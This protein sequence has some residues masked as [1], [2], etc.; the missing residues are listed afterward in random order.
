MTLFYC[1]MLQIRSVVC[2]T[3]IR[4]I[5]QL[6]TLFP[7]SVWHSLHSSRFLWGEG[8]GIFSDRALESNVSRCSGTVKA[9]AGGWRTVSWAALW[10]GPFFSTWWS[11]Y[12][13]FSYYSLTV[14][15]KVFLKTC[16][17]T[18]R[19]CTNRIFIHMISALPSLTTSFSV[20]ANAQF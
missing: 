17:A 8:D 3:Q 10:F 4:Q 5:C 11:S 1:Y 20:L 15:D 16:K 9:P 14:H 2:A 12:R 6:I 18:N 19:Q 7:S 13:L